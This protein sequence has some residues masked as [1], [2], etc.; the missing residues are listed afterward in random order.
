[1]LS[2]SPR[3]PKAGPIIFI[4]QECV[5]RKLK[6][7][8]KIGYSPG[9]PGV[10][11]RYSRGVSKDT[12]LVIFSRCMAFGNFFD[13][14]YTV[15]GESFAPVPPVTSLPPTR[16]VGAQRIL[17][18]C[19]TKRVSLVYILNPATSKGAG[20][21]IHLTQRL[22]GL[23]STNRMK[24]H[25]RVVSTSS[26]RICY[27]VSVKAKGSLSR[28]R[29]VPCR[30]VSVIP[31]NAGCGVFR[32][33]HSF[34]G[35]CDSVHSENVVPVLYNKDKLCVRTTA[36]KCSLPR[37]PTSARLETRLRGGSSRRLMT[38]LT[39]LGPLR[40]AASCSAHGHLVETLRVTVCRARRPVGHATMLPGGACCVKALMD[41][42]RHGTQVS[43]HLSTH[44]R[45]KVIS[46]ME[47]LLSNARPTLTPSREPVPT[48]SLVCCNLRCGFLALC[49]V[50]RLD[51]SQVHA[52][53]TATVR[54]FTGHRVA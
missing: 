33:R 7:G 43:H 45:R 52:R 32:C 47:G 18:G 54:R 53:L 3:A 37:I 40:G 5:F 23:L 19:L 27:K 48:R 34:R 13:C 44:L 20:C 51:C 22:G 50:K 2:L 16:R 29:R 8:V 12:G 28:C 35:T 15:T 41:E 10:F 17:S 30:L 6:G 14:L 4:P 11:P 9:I 49:V 46:R 25:I 39:R 24:S 31:T 42:R 26:H 38:E 1:M 36:Y 21:T